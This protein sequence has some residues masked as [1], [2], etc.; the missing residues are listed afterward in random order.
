MNP[1]VGEIALGVYAVLLAVGGV[2]GYAKAK[3][4]ASLIAGLVSAV[5]A[6]ACVGLILLGQSAGWYLGILLAGLLLGFFGTRFARTRKVMP[7]GMMTAVS[8]LVLAIL[9]AQLT[10]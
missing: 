3:S 9:V 5:M 8:F 6:L 7:G 10:A 1:L 2:V 4:Q